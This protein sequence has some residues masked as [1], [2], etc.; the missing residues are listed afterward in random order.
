MVAR[1]QRKPAHRDAVVTEFKSIVLSH[2]DRD[3]EA[4]R[5]RELG[6]LQRGRKAREKQQ[7]LPTTDPVAQ[8]AAGKT[9]NVNAKSI[10]KDIDFNSLPDFSPSI[11]TL[12]YKGFSKCN[13][14]GKPSNLSEDH[15][16]YLLHPEE[17]SLAAIL[18]M[19]CATYL[20]SKRRIFIACIECLEDGIPFRKTNS[21]QAC[22][23]DVNKASRLWEAFNS[24]G[25]FQ[26]WHFFR[27]LGGAYKLGERN[28]SENSR[29]R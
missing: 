27:V 3:R 7:K 2:F 6:Y 15:N 11:F 14:I 8:T 21:Q 29:E 25:W 10:H 12:D 22:R 28:F 26:E 23:I 4:W 20:T 9:T 16:S 17:I 18:H 5:K 24:V 13:R 19:D 1:K